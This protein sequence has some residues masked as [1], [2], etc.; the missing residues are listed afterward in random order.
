MN[1]QK[2]FKEFIVL[3]NA[4]R[5]EYLIVG[6]YAVSFYS[7]PK[8]TQD[9]DFWIRPT[10]INAKK[11]MMVLK[12]FGFSSLD[13][14]MHD[15]INPGKIIELGNPPLRIDL[16]NRISGVKFAEAY[17]HKS[18]GNYFG[19]PAAFIG[20]DDLIRNKKA[21]GRKKDLDDLDW[22]KRYSSSK[23]NPK[24]IK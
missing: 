9:I 4:K 8:L 5:V 12:E 14:T 6:G 17:K 1:I 21:A 3:L 22:V 15:L 24:D 7:Q 11:I 19:I 2:D 20:K 10:L 23:K 13:I 16:I 18:M